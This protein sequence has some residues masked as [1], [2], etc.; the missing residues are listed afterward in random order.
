ME[1]IVYKNFSLN[2]DFFYL[3]YIGKIKTWG[4][5]RFLLKPLADLYQRPVKV[6]AIMPDYH[7]SY[8]ME[9]IVIMNDRSKELSLKDGCVH[10]HP[11][12]ESSFYELA[13]KSRFIRELF[14][15]LLKNQK[16][17]YVNLYHN[18]DSFTLDNQKDISV[19]G[20]KKEL[21][22]KYDSKINQ[23]LMAKKLGLPVL[24]FEI[25]K[26]RDE[27]LTIFKKKE[28]QKKGAYIAG[29]FGVGGSSSLFA[30]SES[31]IINK[32]PDSSGPFLIMELIKNTVSPTVLGVVA[33]ENEVCI[34][35]VIDQIMD[36]PKYKGAVFPSAI[37]ESI[38][39]KMKEIT[40]KIGKIMGKDGYR[41]IFGCDFIVSPDNRVYF[42]EI[43]PR[44]M[45]STLESSLYLKNLF[46]DCPSLPELEFRAVT[47]GTFD[48]DIKDFSFKPDAPC[49][50]ISYVRTL[51]KK[52]VTKDIGNLPEEEELF[53]DLDC[54]D[55]KKDRISVMDHV[56]AGTIVDRGYLGRVITVDKNQSSVRRNLKKGEQLVWDTVTSCAATG[57]NSSDASGLSLIMEGDK[58][59][60]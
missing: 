53:K 49:W 47:K 37:D 35:T 60:T 46:P 23:Y 2:K 38:I 33:N 9:N 40:F 59:G 27:L 57:S 14:S 42:V 29:E 8:P 39:K 34:A 4:L 6:L 1:H 3:V 31:D 7:Q 43:N 44:K 11:I 20:P 54:L 48:T 36:G 21:V 28:Y 17:I 22:K 5:N 45:G 12:A 15:K 18:S 30:R 51:E 32:F 50:G 56:G 25:A 55:K 26:N 19:I 58:N 24:D 10:K 52:T 41:G 13:S 16:N